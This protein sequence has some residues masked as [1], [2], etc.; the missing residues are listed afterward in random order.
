MC[1]GRGRRIAA[2]G[3]DG[4]A[5]QPS[6]QPA[7]A[8]AMPIPRFADAFPAAVTRGHGRRRIGLALALL[9]LA[10]AA[11]P[12]ARMAAAPGAADDGRWTGTWGTGLAGPAL[13]AE[14]LALQGQTLRL[15]VHT[16]IGGRRARIRLSNR[17]GTAPLRVQAA[18]LALRRDGADIVAG[19][20]R[21]LRFAGRAEVLIPAGASVQSDPVTLEV[22]ALADLAISLYV[23]DK[24][25]A[26]TAQAAAYQM[27]YVSPPGDFTGAASLPVAHRIPAWPFL[28]EVDVD[29]GDAQGGAAVVVFGD[30]IA[31]GA[32][33]T[34]DANRRWP[35][36]LARRLI[37]DDKHADDKPAGGARLGIVNRGI[38]G[39][40]LLRDPASQPIFGQAA[41]RRF[42]RD[43]AGTA[44]VRAVIVALG[45]N[46]IGH[47]GMQGIPAAELPSADALIAGYRT[48]VDEAHRR[49]IAAIG[50][51]LTPVEGTTYPG[52]ATPEKD[53]VRQAVN[54]WIRQPG[55]F[56]GLVDADR[57]V[58]DPAHPAR[59]LP[60]YDSGDHLHPNDAGMQAIA[61]AVPLGMLREAA[62][63]YRG[64]GR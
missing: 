61:D 62:R 36:L 59:L 14:A 55:H 30:S 8:L 24:A 21:A 28:E 4:Y 60:A 27:S 6:R 34:M 5:R 64:A 56:D 37:G 58:R 2:G 20:S 19:S 23:P 39:N 40:R 49:G 46:D 33:T 31:S 16:S 1:I 22:P 10:A 17:F 9:A 38:G 63:S 51:T 11:L 13:P 12:W 47:P 52:Y 41:L 3:E 44:G 48:L 15:V 25:S 45:I 57:A 32:V 7:K 26:T 54:A 18:Q 43:V 29:A 50:V 53:S 42:G 35:D